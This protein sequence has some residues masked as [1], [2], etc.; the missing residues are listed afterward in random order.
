MTQH[1]TG[2]NWYFEIGLRSVYILLQAMNAQKALSPYLRYLSP[3]SG[4]KQL[5]VIKSP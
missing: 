2:E 1:C 3:N 4:G 5:K